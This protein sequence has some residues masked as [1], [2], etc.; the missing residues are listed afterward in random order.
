MRIQGQVLQYDPFTPIPGVNV[1]EVA[2]GRTAQT[3]A[4]GR[5]SIEVSNLNSVLR[6]S[7]VGYDYD[8]YTAAEVLEYSYITLYP[9]STMLDEVIVNKPKTEVKI[10]WVGLGIA[11]VLA[12]AIGRAVNK[13]NKPTAQKP[14]KITI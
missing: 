11:T 12:F 6:F 10:P 8:E 14:K 4:D 13:S 1:K 7:H 5:F 2:T 3:D 9:D